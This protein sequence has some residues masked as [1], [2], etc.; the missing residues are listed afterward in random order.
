MKKLD[1]NRKSIPKDQLKNK[2]SWTDSVSGRLRTDNWD[3]YYENLPTKLNNTFHENKEIISSLKKTY[4]IY[5]NIIGPFHILPDFLFLG[6]GACGTTSIL[7]LY[8]RSNNA[9]F[10]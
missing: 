10:P 7:E 1:E 5:C 6:P 2:S 8:F 4:Q 3:S 9:I